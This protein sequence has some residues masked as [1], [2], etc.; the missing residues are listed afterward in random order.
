MQHCF[1]RLRRG[2]PRFPVL[3]HRV[4][5][6]FAATGILVGI[7]TAATAQSLDVDTSSAFVEPGAP[8]SATLVAEPVWAAPPPLRT[9]ILP[10]ARGRGW[11]WAPG[12]W[13]WTGRT[14]I[15][16][17]GRWLPPRRGY[18]YIPAHWE[19]IRGA[20]LFIPARWTLLPY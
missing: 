8:A 13:R 5:A 3:A 10:P 18:Q 12:Y 14:Y 1:R 7:P 15:W 20:W 4:L 11:V 6:A 9:E 16:I 17:E 19:R 2:F